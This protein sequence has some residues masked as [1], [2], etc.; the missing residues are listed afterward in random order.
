MTRHPESGVT[1][2]A[3]H[4]ASAHCQ[5]RRRSSAG[6]IESRFLRGKEFVRFKNLCRSVRICGSGVFSPVQWRPKIQFILSILVRQESSVVLVN[7]KVFIMEN[8]RKPCSQLCGWQEQSCRSKPE[9]A[10][11]RA[12]VFRELESASLNLDESGQPARMGEASINPPGTTGSGGWTL[13]GERRQRASKEPSGTW[14]A[15]HSSSTVRQERLPAKSHNGGKGY[16]VESERPIVAMK[17]RLESGWSQG[18]L[19]KASR[20]RDPWS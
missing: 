14:E 18:A 4:D 5:Q 2:T 10:K 1:A 9:A 16:A 12:V 13:R 7:C 19:A 15:R 20:V 17:F 8:G 11:A 3:L 6:T